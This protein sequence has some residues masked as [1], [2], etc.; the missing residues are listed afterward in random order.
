MMNVLLDV[1]KESIKS[2]N[3]DKTV[4]EHIVQYITFNKNKF[5]RKGKEM[6]KGEVLGKLANKNGYVELAMTEVKFEEMI[7]EGGYEDKNVVLKELRSKGILSCDK[8]RYT[9]M[10]Q[11]DDGI[12]TKFVVLRLPKKEKQIEIKKTA[13][14][15]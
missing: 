8:D 5:E 3:F 1:E 4:M 7:K 11:N 6:P 15:R 2:R 10:R 12:L 13:K 9:R 14:P